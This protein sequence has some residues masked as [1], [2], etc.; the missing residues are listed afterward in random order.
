MSLEELRLLYH[1]GVIKKKARS[2][3]KNDFVKHFGYSTDQQFTMMMAVSSIEI[4]T[5]KELE[6]LSETIT[7][8]HQHYTVHSN[9]LSLQS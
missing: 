7:R 3:I 5:P 8:Y 9:Q 6:W 2:E 4:P 1:D